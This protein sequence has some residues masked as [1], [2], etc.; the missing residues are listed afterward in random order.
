MLATTVGDGALITQVLLALVIVPSI[1]WILSSVT[2]FAQSQQ[3]KFWKQA[4]W[5]GVRNE[6]FAGLRA[7]F[8]TLSH[9]REI[10]EAGY[11]EV[12]RNLTS[13]YHIYED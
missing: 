8:R 13:Q 9:M 5:A 3:T 2:G 12:W 1:Y 10:A 4:S 7:K 11:E 6:W